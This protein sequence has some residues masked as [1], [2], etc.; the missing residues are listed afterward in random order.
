MAS[1]HQGHMLCPRSEHRGNGW[2]PWLTT[3]IARTLTTKK[4]HPCHAYTTAWGSQG[5]Q[6]C[7][8]YL[9]YFARYRRKRQ[10]FFIMSAA[11]PCVLRHFD[12]SKGRLHVRQSNNHIECKS[13]N[14]KKPDRGDNDASELKQSNDLSTMG[15]KRG[16]REQT[17]RRVRLGLPWRLAS[18]FSCE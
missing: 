12:H 6:M 15:E 8:G 17:W 10:P 7:Y 9:S 11:H 14:G 1:P 4:G 18:L 5:A 3:G 16:R 2:L 13:A